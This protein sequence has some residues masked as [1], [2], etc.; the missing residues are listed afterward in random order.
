MVLFQVA[1]RH[2]GR[3]NSSHADVPIVEYFLN[4]ANGSFGGVV[5]NR[6]QERGPGGLGPPGWYCDGPMLASCHGLAPNGRGAFGC[7]VKRRLSEGDGSLPWDC[8]R[9]A[10]PARPS[11]EPIKNIL[12]EDDL[13][14]GEGA[15]ET[16]PMA[17]PVS[18]CPPQN[19]H[20]S[21]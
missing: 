9:M 2:L 3:D 18:A 15:A 17:D 5:P 16:R 6:P 4:R 8:R 13:E 10:S 19:P 21:S 7:P 20:A 12:S 1:S 11:I 14:G